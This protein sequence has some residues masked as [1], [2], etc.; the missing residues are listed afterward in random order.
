MDAR[1]EFDV[2]AP[3]VF[4]LGFSSPFE[5]EP[6]ALDELERT[7]QLA[8]IEP[9][10]VNRADVDDDAALPSEIST[11]HQIFANW[12]RNVDD[13]LVERVLS[14]DASRGSGSVSLPAREQLVKQPVVDQLS[15]ALSAIVKRPRTSFESEEGQT[16]VRTTQALGLSHGFEPERRAAGD[17]ERVVG[18]VSVKAGSAADSG[19][20]FAAA[21]TAER[22]VTHALAAMRT[23]GRRPS[24]SLPRAGSIRVDHQTRTT[25]FI[26]DR[27]K[28]EGAFLEKA[29]DAAGL[30]GVFFR[31]RL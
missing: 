10:A 1:R 19:E 11:Q 9:D 13:R 16:A 18:A 31:D 12:T 8:A 4:F 21:A 5:L 27:G 7:G 6:A 17:T 2:G 3:L 28:P 20:L 15:S 25:P 30:A 29:I 26:D 24:V 23:K 22:V 14:N